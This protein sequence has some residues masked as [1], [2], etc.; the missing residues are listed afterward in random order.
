MINDAMFRGQIETQ[1]VMNGICAGFKDPPKMCK[2]LLNNEDIEHSLGVGT[3][4]F[5]DG[6]HI[7]SVVGLCLM[8][9]IILIVYL[10]FYRRQAKRQMKKQMDQKIETAVNHYVQLSQADQSDLK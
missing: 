2:R 4:Y 1:A 5:N 3:I 10:M 7:R 6:Y 8:F 9:M